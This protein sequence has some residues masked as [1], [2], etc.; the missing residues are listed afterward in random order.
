MSEIVNVV[1]WSDN[2]EELK[3]NLSQ[4][5]DQIEA[6]RAG[7]EKLAQSLGGDKLI[8]AAH[9]YVAAVE[10][11]GGASNLIESNQARVNAVLTKA[12]E[13]YTALGKTAPTA[14]LALAEAT[15][16]AVQP[17]DELATQS[18]RLAKELGGGGVTQSANAYVAAVE[19]LG[20]ASKLTAAEQANVNSVLVQALDKYK[21]LGQSAPPGVIALADATKK[22]SEAT[23]GWIPLL[24]E[25]GNSWVARITEGILLRDAIHGV[26]GVIKDVATALPEIALKGAAVADVEENF[27]RLTA[28]ANLLGD[29]LLGALRTGT[30][31][32]VTDFELMKTVNQDLAAG[33]RL[34]DK[35]FGTL[36]QGAF[37][38]A[39]ATGGD[40]K[41][42]LDTMN[43]AMLTGRTRALALLTGKVDLEAAETKYAASLGTTRDHLT[44]EGKLEAARA[45]ILDSVSAATGRLGEQTDGLDE[46]VAQLSTSWDN[47]KENLGKVI[48]TSPVIDAALTGIKDSITGTF[49]ASEQ[50]LIQAI[51]KAVDDTAIE[52]INLAETGVES[53]GF[54][55][56]EYYAVQKVFGDVIQIVDGVILAFKGASLAVAELLSVGNNVGPF[57]E[58]VKRIK[59]E[60]DKLEDS[61][62][63]RG[64]SLMAADAAQKDVDAGTVR[65]TAVLEGLRKKMEEARDTT[66]EFIGPLQD[67]AQG[68][69]AAAAAAAAQ[70]AALAKT[71]EEQAK[72]AAEQKKYADALDAVN[73]S[74][75]GLFAGLDQLSEGYRQDIRDAIASGTTVKDLSIAWGLHEE[76]IK[77][78]IEADKVHAE[79]QKLG[80]SATIAQE[81][82]LKKLGVTQSKE[83]QMLRES[84]ASRQ[85]LHSNRVIEV[86]DLKKVGGE[87]SVVI[88]EQEQLLHTLV[89]IDAMWRK[90]AETG[91]AGLENVGHQSQAVLRAATRG[92][93]QVP[94]DHEV[95]RRRHE[96]SGGDVRATRAGVRRRH[97]RDAQEHR[98]DGG[99]APGRARTGEVVGEGR[100]RARRQ[101]RVHLDGLQPERHEGSACRCRR[102]RDRGG[103]PGRTERHLGDRQ[104]RVHRRECARWRVG[105]RAGWRGVRSRRH[106]HRR[107]GRAGRRP[108][109]WQAGVGEGGRR[110]RA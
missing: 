101:L 55:V 80:T 19:K 30:H 53:G 108:D 27:K 6:T 51:A 94:A 110:D 39:Q 72:A 107:G 16:K 23:G 9:R 83:I 69:G 36:A 74:S 105:R 52:L 109:S 38:L 33:L 49:G 8:A 47:F 2:T 85:A 63:A 61:M 68:H 29:A 77:A 103:R 81:S 25:M 13:Q 10:E 93:G 22:A 60:I 24:R 43:D 97:G 73:R 1:R 50:E 41:T 100:V 5:L 91:A 92:P 26:I 62:M 76:T 66:H 59:E 99:A 70:A 20:G 88:S 34:T 46:R 28:Q 58:D 54:L 78:V 79:T 11:A 67:E 90:G 86:E 32:T 95:E 3:R 87:T 21:A 48:A 14:M 89:Q 104:P 65:A 84:E 96:G 71:K 56:K 37:A 98:P 82:E 35:Q 4:G 18:E 42:A 17:V 64:K 40:V 31:N 102:R 57:R 15:K 106:R 44:D 45:A 75:S 12:I 7:A